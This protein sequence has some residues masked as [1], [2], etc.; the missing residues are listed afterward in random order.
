MYRFYTRIQN[1][2]SFG[3][4]FISFDLTQQDFRSNPRLSYYIK[5]WFIDID[6]L[7][8]YLVLNANLQITLVL[9]D[10]ISSLV[11]DNY[12]PIFPQITRTI[13]VG[14][15]RFSYENVEYFSNTQS[16]V[17]HLSFT[18]RNR[19]RLYITFDSWPVERTSYDLSKHTA[20]Y[21]WYQYFYYILSCL[22]QTDVA[23]KEMLN[24]VKAFHTKQTEII[25]RSCS[26]FVQTYNSNEIIKWYTRESFFYILLN[27]TLRSEDI[28]H[29][30]AMRYVIS[31]LENYIQNH[32][33]E[34]HSIAR[35]YRGQQMHLEEILE[36]QANIGGLIGLT[37]FWSTTLSRDT[38]FDFTSILSPHRTDQ[39]GQVL[40]SIDI[41]QHIQGAYC[42]ISQFSV[43]DHELEIL[44]S[45]RS[46]FRVE[47]VTKNTL[48]EFWYIDLTLI[49][50]NDEQ[51]VSIMNPWYL[52]TK[53]I[54]N[55]RSFFTLQNIQSKKNFFHDLTL[56]NGS[57]LASQL[58][59]DMML[60]LDQND[61]ARNELLDV[62]RE[63]YAE[64]TVELKKIDHFDATYDPR[65]AIKWYSVD[66]F[67]YRLINRALR[68]ENIDRI[69]KLRYFI[70]D[71]HNQLAQMQMEFLRQLPSNQRVLQLYR[72]LRMHLCELHQ[73]QKNRGHLVST[74]TFLSTT[75]DYEAALAFS[76]DG[77]VEEN[78]ISVI[79][80]I[81]VDTTMKQSIPFASLVYQ[82]IFKDEDEVLFSMGAVFS[83]GE[84]KQLR[85]RL[86][87]IKLA[88]TSIEDEQWNVFTSH[89]S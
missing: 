14:T 20:K 62:C 16:L 42:D 58:F 80:C 4:C 8:D 9:S 23:Q 7:F 29:I 13:I 17:D 40:F 5:H 27:R 83:V 44:F 67:L 64:D 73:L 32:R 43:A 79:Y 38:A 30:F 85:D 36:I 54:L 55:Q 60:R 74:N 50:E 2:D 87:T 53:D 11:C 37:A 34:I 22:K 39:I 45:F 84:S 12:R 75:S 21:L 46:L 63:A 88:L 76:G 86:W 71:L 52:R 3:Q 68:N 26:E 35:I 49:D 41:P 82:S 77:N 24:N 47:R 59:I 18:I 70:H 57:F 78:S 1:S 61:F 48:D 25:Q 6:D 33:H 69:F 66:C 10:L 51:F 65:D 89:F 28:N 81:L 31:D 72:G 19:H 56:E 15:R